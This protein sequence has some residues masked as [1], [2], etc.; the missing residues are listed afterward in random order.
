[1]GVIVFAWMIAVEFGVLFQCV[2]LA[3][4]WD[5]VRMKTAH[6]INRNSFYR[7]ISIASL[8]TDVLILLMPFPVI[9]GLNNSIKRKLSLCALFALGSLYVVSQSNLTANNDDG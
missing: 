3:G 1:M 6:C 2:P 5:L 7:G 4:A 8:I 9:W